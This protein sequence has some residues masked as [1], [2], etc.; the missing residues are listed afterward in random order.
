MRRGGKKREGRKEDCE[1]DKENKG[2]RAG[3]GQKSDRSRTEGRLRRDGREKTRE[4]R[5]RQETE[6]KREEKQ[7]RE[8]KKR[9]AER[10]RERGNDKKEETEAEGESGTVV[11]AVLV[12]NGYVDWDAGGGCGACRLPEVDGDRF[13]G[14]ASSPGSEYGRMPNPARSGLFPSGS[15]SHDRAGCRRSPDRI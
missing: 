15:G 4:T 3:A 12:R 14:D 7:R 11:S 10:E 1:E 13:G 8:R 9:K 5:E 6:G 2:D